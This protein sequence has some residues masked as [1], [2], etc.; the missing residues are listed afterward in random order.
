MEVRLED[1]PRC[2]RCTGPVTLL[3]QVSHHLTASGGASVGHRTI[4]LCPTCD[5][6]DPDAQGIL[7]FFAVHETVTDDNLPTVAQL[8]EEWTTRAASRTTAHPEH[9]AEDERADYE[10]YLR[11]R[12]DEL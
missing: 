3:A 7:A 9:R 8:I 5:H 10:D 6:D 1:D 12:D 11:W 4:G 2:H